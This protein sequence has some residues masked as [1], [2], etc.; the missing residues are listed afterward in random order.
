MDEITDTGFSLL[1][2]G[3]T[4]LINGT[5]ESP[6]T[7]RRIDS[8]NVKTYAGPLQ[9]WEIGSGMKS[10]TTQTLKST[11]RIENTE[12]EGNADIRIDFV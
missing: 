12:T 2:G 7:Y 10:D 9:W 3:D 6:V 11:K 5:P 4:V 8:S 1:H